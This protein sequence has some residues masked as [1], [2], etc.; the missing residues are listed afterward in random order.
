MSTIRIDCDTVAQTFLF[1]KC[2]N[3]EQIEETQSGMI[4]IQK[5]IDKLSINSVSGLTKL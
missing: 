4:M 3:D 5:L 1:E 2:F